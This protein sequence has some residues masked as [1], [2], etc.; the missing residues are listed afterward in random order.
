MGKEQRLQVKI[1]ELQEKW[2][3]L[4]FKLRKL[5]EERILETDPAPISN[6]RERINAVKVERE[7]IE[8]ELS[9]LEQQLKDIERKT[10]KID[11]PFTIVRRKILI[12]AANPKTTPR[13]RLDEE[14]REIEEGLR[15]SKHRDQ[16][17]IS[18]RIAVRLRDI[19]RVLLDYEPHIVH[20]AGHGEKDGLLVEDE[21]G[22]AM[23]IS[24]KALAGLFKLASNHVEC[25]ILSACYSAPQADAIGKHINYV[26]GMRGEIED[27]VAIEFAA[28]FYDAL[29]AGKSVEE[30]FEF[31]RM[32][33]RLYNMPDQFVPILHKKH[34][35]VKKR[36]H[37]EQTQNVTVGVDSKQKS[38]IK[39][40]NLIS[41]PFAQA[42]ILVQSNTKSENKSF[43]YL[44]AIRET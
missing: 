22:M 34:R 15:R 16:F 31:G 9:D 28:G 20:F 25:V 41:G 30:A 27:K 18:S 37:V 36:P 35:E 12:L 24:S 6:L 5:E 13:L 2:Q 19:R 44:S 26:I 32:A 8:Q 33:I 29:G 1:D 23:L 10:S 40:S 42:D 39:E 14:F 38:V 11:K 4:T 7:E 21:L 17:E 3:L 43:E